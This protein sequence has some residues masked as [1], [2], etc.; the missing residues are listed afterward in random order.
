MC[1]AGGVRVLA[2]AVLALGV[3]AC[4]G[5]EE[6]QLYEVTMDVTYRE[7]LRAP[8]FGYVLHEFRLDYRLAAAAEAGDVAEPEAAGTAAWTIRC[9][10][11]AFAPDQEP[12]AEF[13][14]THPAIFEW[15]RGD[16]RRADILE[17]DVDWTAGPAVLL[18]EGEGT[19]AVV[20]RLPAAIAADREIGCDPDDRYTAL[21]LSLG[22][23][24][25]TAPGRVVTD[26][27]E[28]SRAEAL[29]DAAGEMRYV[30]GEDGSGWLVLEVPRE[31]L[32]ATLTPFAFTYDP[33]REPEGGADFVVEGTLRVAPTE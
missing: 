16:L 31:T 23:A 8:G 2:A 4:G 17:G 20:H 15:E 18:V 24:A 6:A 3:A 21:A 19:V 30:L 26:T 5:G 29:N 32:S 14:G 25:M 10:E 33:G 1:N 11:D 12:F 13:S 27:E 7:E 9:Y 28:F 22:D